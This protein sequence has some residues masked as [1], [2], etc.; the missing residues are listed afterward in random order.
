M[1]QSKRILQY[2][3]F[4]V[5]Y[6]ALTKVASYIENQKTHHK[7][8]SFINEYVRFLHENGIDYDEK[9]LFDQL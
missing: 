5:S 2:A 9:Y 3:G 6:K 7:Q 8:N 4:S 1:D